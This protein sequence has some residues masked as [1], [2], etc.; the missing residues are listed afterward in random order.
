MG[1]F[2]ILGQ[3]KNFIVWLSQYG[4]WFGFVLALVGS[5]EQI[6]HPSPDPIWSSIFGFPILH[7]YL[8][9][10]LILGISL[11]IYMWNNIKG[12][13][14][15]IR[16][17]TTNY[18]SSFILIFIGFIILTISAVFNFHG[19]AQVDMINVGPVWSY[20]PL[21]NLGYAWVIPQ[22]PWSVTRYADQYFQDG[23][24]YR[25]TVGGA[26]DFFLGMIAMG[27][28]LAIIGMCLLMFGLI[29]FFNQKLRKVNQPLF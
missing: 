29:L 8:I 23:P 17:F 24:I 25:G 3:I 1:L 4:I 5:F 2:R 15:M 6:L 7:H 14:R 26:Y 20:P 10:F 19:I 12:N 13:L 27:W 21:T 28:I 11:L 18:T 9:G 16:Y 22:V